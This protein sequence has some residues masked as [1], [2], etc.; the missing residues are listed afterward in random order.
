M[1]KNAGLL[2]K[3]RKWSSSTSWNE[4]GNAGFNES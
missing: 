2:K 3:P 4:F 1:K